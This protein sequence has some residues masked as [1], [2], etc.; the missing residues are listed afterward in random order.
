MINLSLY[1]TQ[2]SKCGGKY[3]HDSNPK[4]HLRKEKSHISNDFGTYSKR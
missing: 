1:A 3:T 2:E 4:F